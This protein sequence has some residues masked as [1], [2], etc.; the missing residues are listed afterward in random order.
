MS[1]KKKRIRS[2]FRDLV[3][4]RDGYK[5]VM[6]GAPELGIH[7]LDPHHITDRNFMPNGG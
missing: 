1:K 4:S 3:F 6:C 5:C 7:K 2:N